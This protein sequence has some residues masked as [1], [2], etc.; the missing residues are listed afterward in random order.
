MTLVRPASRAAIHVPLLDFALAGL[1]AL[2]AALVGW[3]GYGGVLAW[4]LA[5]VF[6]AHAC[7]SVRVLRARDGRLRVTSLFR[8]DAFAAAACVFGVAPVPYARLPRYRVYV[9]DRAHRRDVAEVASE[10]QGDELVRR[11]LREVLGRAPGEAGASL[12]EADVSAERA[13]WKGAQA[14]A[15]AQVST[16]YASTTHRRRVRWMLIA[17]AVYGLAMLLYAL[18]SGKPP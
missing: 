7:C 3:P 9:A 18:A 6:F 13:Q 8:R 1:V 10:G 17:V 11:L 12:V 2:A 16:Y 5:A 14:M 15:Q 4:L